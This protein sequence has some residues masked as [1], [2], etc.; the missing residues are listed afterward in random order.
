MWRNRTGLTDYR[1]AG[2]DGVKPLPTSPKGRLKT[3]SQKNELLKLKITIL[4]KILPFG[5][6]WRGYYENNRNPFIWQKR[7]SDGRI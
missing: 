1:R 6:V 2:D 3:Y 5:E 4:T 7:S